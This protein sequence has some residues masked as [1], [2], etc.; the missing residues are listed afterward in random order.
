MQNRVSLR[1]YVELPETEAFA[2]IMPRE[3]SVD[4]DTQIDFRLAEL[5]IIKH[6]RPGATK[7]DMENAWKTNRPFT[8][9][10]LFSEIWVTVHLLLGFLCS[11]IMIYTPYLW[12][13]YIML[14]YN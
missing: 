2:Y 6:N 12:I 8:S 10:Y 14:G 7:E 11:F 3:R 4:I 9:K 13:G 5:L 1:W